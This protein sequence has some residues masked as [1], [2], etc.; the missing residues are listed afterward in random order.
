MNTVQMR[1]DTASLLAEWGQT[2]I[3]ERMSRT[4]TTGRASISWTSAGSIVGD[5]QSISGTTM[6]EEEGLETKSD[7]EII[8]TYD[9]DVQV[10]D[11]IKVPGIG[12]V[13]V[14]GVKE[15]DDHKT[16][17]VTRTSQSK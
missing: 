7:A 9:A 6:V 15:W 3:V 4:W 13:Y 5:Y 10:G 16:I 11:R 14:M 17:A 8:T 12:W 2:L 1:A